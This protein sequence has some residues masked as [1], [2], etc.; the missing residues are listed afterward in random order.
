MNLEKSA[1]LGRAPVNVWHKK[2]M[3][4]I[5][6]KP[7]VMG[8]PTV[9]TQSDPELDELADTLLLHQR[10]TDR[11]LADYLC[12]ADQRIQDFLNDHLEGTGANIKLPARTFVLDRYGLARALSL[13]PDR[14]EFFSELLK[15][16][17][18]RQGVLHN[19]LS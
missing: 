8:C 15:S 6:L 7:A 4:Y 17:R 9:T 12:P 13:P 14:D 10:E 2:T 18:V 1:G 3:L 5:N 16:Y 19:P 11:L